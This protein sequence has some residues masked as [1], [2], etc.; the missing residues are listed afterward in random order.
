MFWAGWADYFAV[1]FYLPVHPSNAPAPLDAVQAIVDETGHAHLNGEFADWVDGAR[2]DHL[3][4]EI[5][6][7]EDANG[8]F[9][10]TRKGTLDGQGTGDCDCFGHGAHGMALQ[11]VVYVSEL[12]VGGGRQVAWEQVREGE[13]V[14]AGF[15]VSGL[16]EEFP[17]EKLGVFNLTIEAIFGDGSLVGDSCNQNHFECMELDIRVDDCEEELA[18]KEGAG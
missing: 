10:A 13:R 18:G 9:V 14:D 4:I 12:A 2:H 8:G 15:V 1:L 16:G 7:R 3:H 11:N 6:R 17:G 5:C